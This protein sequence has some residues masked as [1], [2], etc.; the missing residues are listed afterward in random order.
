MR[1]KA[2]RHMTRPLTV[3]FYPSDDGLN[4]ISPKK[5]TPSRYGSRDDDDAGLDHGP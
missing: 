5:P 4:L 1:G 3:Q 2:R